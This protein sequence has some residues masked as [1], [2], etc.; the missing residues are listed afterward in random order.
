[1]EN[2]TG[3][4]N[5]IVIGAASGYA[6]EYIEAWAMSLIMSGFE[7]IRTLLLYDGHEHNES[8]S[9]LL[10]SNGFRIIRKGQSGGV[11]NER[12]ADIANV[13]RELEEPARYAVVTDVRDVYFQSDPISWLENNLTKPLLAVSEGVRYSDESWNRDNLRNGFPEH[14]DRILPNIVCN[15]GVIAG[16]VRVVA[17]VCLA[18]SMFAKSSGFGVA[19]Q[20]AYNLLLDMEPYRSIVQLAQSEDGFGCQAGTMAHPDGMLKS[21]LLEPQPVLDSEGVKTASGKLYPIVHQYD[22]VPEWDRALRRVLEPQILRSY[23]AYL[24]STARSRSGSAPQRRPSG[25]GKPMVSLVCPTYQRSSFLR[26]AIRYFFAQDYGGELEMVILDDSPEPDHGL[27]DPKYVEMGIRYYHMPLKRLTMGTKMNL[28][29]QL[30][31]GDILVQY[32]DDDYYAPNYVERMV[33]FLG[34]ADFLTLSGWFVYSTEHRSLFYWQADITSPE[35]FVVRPTEPVKSVSTLEWDPS[36]TTGNM[37]G[38]GFSYV[39]RKSVFPTVVMPDVPDDGLFW[40]Y[41]FYSRLER[42]G[43]RT[44]CRPDTEGIV[45]HILHPQSSTCQV[46][47]WILPEFLVQKLFSGFRGIKENDSPRLAQ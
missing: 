17:D 14:A 12:F 20:S 21:V 10:Q 28:L 39:W 29:T 36:W 22:R 2:K 37:W 8:V 15:V 45:L 11:Y 33:E 27:T 44:V 6:W 43:L 4:T 19:D 13:L 25:T 34:D 42:A 7:G 32:D 16:D 31:Q 3:T 40:D 23:L 30:A 46:P 47:Q 35:H 26:E 5:D 1:M 24:E 9:D 38:Y 41:D 18:V